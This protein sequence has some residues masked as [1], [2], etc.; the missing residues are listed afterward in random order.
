MR[1]FTIGLLTAVGIAI[2]LP[3]HAEDAYV[4]VGYDRGT[5]RQGSRNQSKERIFRDVDRREADDRARWWRTDHQH[6]LGAR[7]LADAGQHRLLLGEGW[8]ADADPHRRR[9]TGGARDPGGRGRAR[10]GGDTD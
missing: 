2:V 7:G 6:Y 10:R 4:G 1:A 5:V 8:H 3:A 9:R